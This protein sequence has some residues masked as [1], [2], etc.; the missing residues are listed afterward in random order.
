MPPIVLQIHVTNKTEAP[1]DVSVTQCDS[2]LG[3][4]VVM[5][6]KMTVQPHGTVDT[7]RMT[8]RLGY[9]GGA[10][11]VTVSLKANGKREKQVITLTPIPEP[12]ANPPTQPAPTADHGADSKAN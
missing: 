4:F 11:P 7:E 12:A 2:D 8:S 3:N 6:E 1:I 10:L 9:M 5:P